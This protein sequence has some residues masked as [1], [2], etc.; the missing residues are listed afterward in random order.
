MR[1]LINACCPIYVG[2]RVSYNRLNSL[3]YKYLCSKAGWYRS[4]TAYPSLIGY[5]SSPK[6]LRTPLFV[7]AGPRGPSCTGTNAMIPDDIRGLRTPLD[8]AESTK[9]DNVQFHFHCP[10]VARTYTVGQISGQ[11]GTPMETT[12]TDER[13]PEENQ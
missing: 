8:R 4:P 3:I 1:V 9:S 11:S 5:G 13:Q 10:S 2:H 6:K 7:A 12:H